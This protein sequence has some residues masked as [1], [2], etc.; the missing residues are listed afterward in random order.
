MQSNIAIGYAR[1]STQGQADD[2]LSLADQEAK[3][4]L[5]CELNNLEL[6]AI[7]VEEGVS[8]RCVPISERPAGSRVIAALDQ[9]KAD[10]VV[11]CKLDRLFRNTAD[12]MITV[13]HWE[14]HKISLHLI[15]F[16]GM[17]LNTSTAIGTVFLTMM[18]AMA[19]FFAEQTSELTSSAL[20]R[21]RDL[22][23][24]IGATPLGW[25]YEGGVLRKD[26]VGQVTRKLARKY[27]QTH[28]LRETAEYLEKRGRVTQ[29]GGTKWYP[30]TVAQIIEPC[31][32]EVSKQKQKVLD[33]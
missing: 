21:K 7:A 27:A 14:R 11:A 10:H 18:A 17:S 15:D 9:R 28:S 1:V 25:R 16:G 22:G 33:D 6:L 12:A 20:R 13:K 8:A 23:E 19:Q 29:R 24:R 31:Y 26:P 3:I 2:G 5:Y 4:R 30:K 32:L